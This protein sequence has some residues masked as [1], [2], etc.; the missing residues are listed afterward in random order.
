[1]YH[2]INI[3]IYSIFGENDESEE[4]VEMIHGFLRNLAPDSSDFAPGFCEAIDVT[5]PF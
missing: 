5:S 3:M 1:M 4:S 2:I